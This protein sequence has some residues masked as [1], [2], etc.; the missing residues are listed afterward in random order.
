VGWCAACRVEALSE[1]EAHVWPGSHRLAY[2]RFET[3]PSAGGHLKITAADQQMM[4]DAGCTQVAV[5]L[6]RGDVVAFQGGRLVHG[7]PPGQPN[8]LRWM[9]YAQ[10]AQNIGMRVRLA[11]C[12]EAVMPTFALSSYRAAY[13]LCL[14]M[15]GPVAGTHPIGRCTREFEAVDRHSRVMRRGTIPAC[16]AHACRA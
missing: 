9:T 3:E 16:G 10:F 2:D 7:G 5:P 14:C 11:P 15:S 12:I 1:T 4:A 13:G 8:H 6:R